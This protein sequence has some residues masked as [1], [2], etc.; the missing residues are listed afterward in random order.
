MTDAERAMVMTEIRV[1]LSATERSLYGKPLDEMTEAELREHNDRH[2]SRLRL[3]LK[4]QRAHAVRVAAP[5]PLAKVLEFRR[6]S[7]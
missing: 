5:R 1:S 3:E 4:A 6:C 7:A 2:A